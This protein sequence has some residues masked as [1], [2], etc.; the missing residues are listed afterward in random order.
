MTDRV[1]VFAPA[2]ILTVTTVALTEGRRSGVAVLSGPA[3]PEVVDPV[4]LEDRR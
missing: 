1:M 4:Q 3:G 2:P